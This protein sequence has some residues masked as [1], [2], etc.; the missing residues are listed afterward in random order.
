MTRIKIKTIKNQ[1][2]GHKNIGAR[3]MH[4]QA[5]LHVQKVDLNVNRKRA[6]Q[7]NKSMHHECIVLGLSHGLMAI[8][9]FMHATV[10]QYN[11]PIRMRY[12][13]LLAV[14]ASEESEKEKRKVHH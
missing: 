14:G 8:P 7:T 10:I 1:F 9:K 2:T 11:V 12:I 13:Q 4:K 3:K 5:H 6:K